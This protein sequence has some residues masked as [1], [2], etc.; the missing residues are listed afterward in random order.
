MV[1]SDRIGL[2]YE[3]PSPCDDVRQP[4]VRRWRRSVVDQGCRLAWRGYPS[5]L[6]ALLVTVCG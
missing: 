6:D 2:G 3:Y 4:L 1:G 5:G